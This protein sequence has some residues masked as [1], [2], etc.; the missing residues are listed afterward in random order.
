MRA[1]RHIN[2]EIFEGLLGKPAEDQAALDHIMLQLD[3]TDNKSHL[4]ANAILG[5]SLAAAKAHAYQQ[6][7]ELFQS[8]VPRDD[9]TLPVPTMN[10]INGG[11][12]ADNNVD[13][14]EFMIIPHGAPSFSEALRY[15]TEVFHALK[16]VLSKKA[17]QLLWR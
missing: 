8:I 16:A 13:I 17:M 3:G 14:Q 7:L 5:V 6:N 15:G 2:T 1:I 11:E 10:I 12:H 4:G 9:Y